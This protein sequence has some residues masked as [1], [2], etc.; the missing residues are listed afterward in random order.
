MSKQE[1]EGAYMPLFANLRVT[2]A[3]FTSQ[4]KFNVTPGTLGSM[5]L[6]KNHLY[7]F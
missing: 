3:P 6:A 1:L 5:E 7:S 4:N 2:F